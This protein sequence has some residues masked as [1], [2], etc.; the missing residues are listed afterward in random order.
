[1]S[2]LLGRAEIDRITRD[3][4][5]EI[6]RVATTPTRRGDQNRLDAQRTLHRGLDYGRFALDRRLRIVLREDLGH[7]STD[8]DASALHNQRKTTDSMP[9]IDILLSATPKLSD[10]E[11]V[12]PQPSLEEMV[13][14]HYR[15]I[16]V[17]GDGSILADRYLERL[18]DLVSASMPE[19]MAPAREETVAAQE[20][21]EL[22]IDDA[23]HVAAPTPDPAAHGPG[24]ASILG[25]TLDFARNIVDEID[26]EQR[27][28]RESAAAAEPTR[29]DPM[30]SLFG[31]PAGRGAGPLLGLIGT[32]L[33][34]AQ[35]R[36]GPKG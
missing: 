15:R 22:P 32:M 29:R 1:M 12:V 30:E 24:M 4:F 23:P 35:R 14:E 26:P 16:D 9:N 36:P 10:G 6:L 8:A 28:R 19:A 34:E 11:Y 20:E 3:R 7:A 33:V 17:S 27:S 18:R 5:E 21:P 25:A 13:R 31:L 2:M